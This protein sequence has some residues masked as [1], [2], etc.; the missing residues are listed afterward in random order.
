MPPGGWE[1]QVNAD[2][3]GTLQPGELGIDSMLPLPAPL[4]FGGPATTRIVKSVLNETGRS[5]TTIEVTPPAA[6]SPHAPELDLREIG[7]ASC[8]ERVYLCV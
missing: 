3:N 7:R 6:G 4:E 5:S 1:V 2:R 8:R